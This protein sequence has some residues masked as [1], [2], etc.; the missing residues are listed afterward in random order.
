MPLQYGL[1][2]KYRGIFNVSPGEMHKSQTINL[3][4][5]IAGLNKID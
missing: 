5:K 3:N 2:G 4:R 1:G